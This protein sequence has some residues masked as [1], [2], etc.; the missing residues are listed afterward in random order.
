MSFAYE[1]LGILNIWNIKFAYVAK[2]LRTPDIWRMMPE[3]REDKNA[4]KARLENNWKPMERGTAV[5]LDFHNILPKN[6]IYYPLA[7]RTYCNG[8]YHWKTKLKSKR[9]S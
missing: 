5:H 3:E 9:I 1:S 6:S 8:T 2:Y 4:K 7:N